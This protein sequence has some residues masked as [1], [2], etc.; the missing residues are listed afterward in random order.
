[1]ICGSQ[2][3]TLPGRSRGA[4]GRLQQLQRVVEERCASRVDKEDIFIQNV[5]LLYIG[6]HPCESLSRVGR[7]ETD[8]VAPPL[9]AYGLK[10]LF[11]VCAVP[12]AR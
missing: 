8:A 9:G 12:P 6:E 5:M 1:M 7:V 10:D 3:V 2:G 11:A 4:G